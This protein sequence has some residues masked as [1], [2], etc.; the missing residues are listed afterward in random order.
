[1]TLCRIS[2]AFLRRNCEQCGNMFN[3]FKSLIKAK[4]AVQ[5]G[6]YLTAGR[7]YES[8]EDYDNALVAYKK[9]DL[10]DEMGCLYQKLNQEEQAIEIYKRNGNV[11]KLIKIYLKR[12]NIEMAGTLLEDNSRFQEAAELYYN[13]EKYDRAAYLYE[14]NGYYKKAAYIYEKSGNLKK[15]AV[16]FEK[17]FTY[18]AESTG[19]YPDNYSQ[20]DNDLF[21]AVELYIKI[22]DFGKAYELLLKNK[23]Y[24]KAARLAIILGK[25]DDA[26]KLFEKAQQPMLAAQVYEKLGQNKRACQF[27]GEAALAQGKTAEAAEWF[28]KSE[29]YIRAAE[30]FVCEKEYEKAA[31]CFFMDQNYLASADNYLKTGS[32]EDAAKMF[33]LGR[34]WRMAADI[35]YK[36]K[37]YQKAGELY[38]KA[39]AFLNAG[40]CFLKVDDD[41]HALANFQKIEENSLDFEKAIIQ[42]SAIFLRTRKP[43]LVIEKVGKKLKDTPINKSNIEWYYML[44]QAY[45]NIGD[46]KRAYEIFR[47]ILTED[48]SFKDIHQKLKEVEALINEYKGMDL[49][50]ENSDKRYKILEKAGEGGMGT[51]YRAED[52]VLKRIVAL[53]ILNKSLI[54]DKRT[55]ERFYSEA[56][57]AASLSHSNI[58]TVYDVG[59]INDDYFISMEFVE[60]E[61]FMKILR[62]KKIFSIPQILFVATK[63]FKALDYSHQKGIIHRDIKP[64]NIMLTLQK[65]IKIVDFGL[66]VIRGEGNKAEIGKIAGTYY[67]MSPEQIQGAN[68]DH[69]TDIY[70]SG[71]TLFHLITGKVPFKGE[72]ILYKHLFEAIPPIKTI[73]SDAP[74]KLVEIVEKCM[75]KRREDRYLSAQEV[76]DELKKIRYSAGEKGMEVY[77]ISVTDSMGFSP[78]DSVFKTD[79]RDGFTD[80]RELETVDRGQ[81]TVNGGYTTESRSGVTNGIESTAEM[82]DSGDMTE[83][84]NS[85]TSLDGTDLFDFEELVSEK[86]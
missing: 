34:H 19:G 15:A 48:D 52:T 22:E 65:E 9:G 41:K 53:K 6:E 81:S 43:Q 14:K 50:E 55:L 33:E 82:E 28:K 85:F 74:D 58:V 37:K 27:R 56:R 72:Y 61:N 64:H 42:V 59:T 86:N 35:S 18:N 46:F 21:K 2:F 84:S 20:I 68:V 4:A 1:L 63:L 67:Y 75:R 7:I 49:L 11:D 69:R 23:K 16:N 32:E 62:K 83:K 76:L 57:S 78:S 38:E 54:K 29:D 13:H 30:L 39:G 12:K 66:A 40:N 44:G 47:G 36:Y 77:N 31:Y 3:K 79:N 51:V 8:I 26:A 5:N 17:W 60:G 71:A 70:S 80:N 10:F 73:R 24:D 25:L 45:E